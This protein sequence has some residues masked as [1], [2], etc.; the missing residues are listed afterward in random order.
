MAK[1]DKPSG[2]MNIVLWILQVL[3]AAF[4]VVVIAP[5]KLLGDPQAIEG[6]N[7]IGFGQ[8]FRYLTGAL[9]ALGGILLVIPALSGA[10]ALLLMCV[11]VGAIATHLFLIG[12]SPLMAIICFVI[13]GIIAWGRKDRLARLFGRA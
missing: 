5:P 7:Q 1:H 4:F 8:W 2:W 9:E 11:L 12:G 6:F 13:N 10:G 3:T